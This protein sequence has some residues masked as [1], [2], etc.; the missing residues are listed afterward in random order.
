M[1]IT[2]RGCLDSLKDADGTISRFGVLYKE[3]EGEVSASMRTHFYFSLP[4]LMKV[5]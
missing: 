3:R 1:G 5:T 2:S 4:L